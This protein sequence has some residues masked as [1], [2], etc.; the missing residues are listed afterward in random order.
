VLIIDDE[1]FFANSLRRALRLHEVTVV[2]NGR[3]AIDTVSE[4]PSFDIILCDLMMPDVT[5][6]D[7]YAW[8]REARPGM[9]ERVVFMTGGSY[10]ARA[11]E[12]LDMVPNPR[13]EKPFDLDKMRDFVREYIVERRAKN[14]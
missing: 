6:M 1:P 5:G 7:V 2:S 14:S 10:T 4:D 3:Q 13:F 12:F 11:N 9:E 8:L